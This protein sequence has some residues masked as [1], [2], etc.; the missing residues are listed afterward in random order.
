MRDS[1]ENEFDRHCSALLVQK[2]R[3]LNLHENI[4]G[5]D[6]PRTLVGTNSRLGIRAGHL[7]N[8]ANFARE[9]LMLDK[10]KESDEGST[11]M[12][13]LNGIFHFEIS[14]VI[15]TMKYPE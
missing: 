13:I 4:R 7:D 5:P 9:G 1:G 3:Y 10:R 2:K 6:G 11:C 12:C 8:T 15:L 14:T